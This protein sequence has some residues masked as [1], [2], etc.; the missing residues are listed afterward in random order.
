MAYK[1]NLP[2]KQAKTLQGFQFLKAQLYMLHE[3]HFYFQAFGG[4]VVV[5]SAIGRQVW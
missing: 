5:V 1:I 2:S 4:F 3:N